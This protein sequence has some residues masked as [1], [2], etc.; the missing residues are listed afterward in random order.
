MSSAKIPEPKD[1]LF[2]SIEGLKLVYLFK[3]EYELRLTIAMST[4][5]KEDQVRDILLRIPPLILGMSSSI[6]NEEEDPT[7]PA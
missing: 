7:N 1:W 6:S 2:E 3:A 5:Q 4:N